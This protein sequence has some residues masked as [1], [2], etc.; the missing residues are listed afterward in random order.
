MQKMCVHVNFL[1][2]VLVVRVVLG[3]LEDP[4]PLGIL[5]VP[6]LLVVLGFRDDQGVRRWEMGQVLA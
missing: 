4:E 1:Y 5:L 2:R 6:L 3:V